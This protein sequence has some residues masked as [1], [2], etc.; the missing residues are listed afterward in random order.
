M[1]ENI[2]ILLDFISNIY[3]FLFLKSYINKKLFSSFNKAD[4]FFLI[5][6]IFI[7]VP[8]KVP[9]RLLF[10]AIADFIYIVLSKKNNVATIIKEY[11]HIQLVLFL[12]S[13]IIFL[14]HSIIFTDFLQF[15]ENDTYL[16]FKQHICNVLLFTVYQSYLNY[17]ASASSSKVISILFSVI[18]HITIFSLSYLIIDISQNIYNPTSLLTITVSILFLIISIILSLY[19]RFIE[20]TNKKI[21]TDEQLARAL[22]LKDYSYQIESSLKEVHSIRHD[23][24]NNLL[25]IRKYAQENRTDK[26]SALANDILGRLNS[27]SI[28]DTGI[29]IISAI[30]NTKS[31]EAQSH[32]INFE[33]TATISFLSI[34]DTDIIIILGNVLDN[35]ITAARKCKNRYIMISLDQQNDLLL[36]RCINNYT[37]EI[38]KKGELFISSKKNDGLIHGIG[39]ENVRKTV[40]K[41]GGTSDFRHKDGVFTVE[42]ILPNYL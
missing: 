8:E 19:H 30:L 24:K 35:A 26:I 16:Y 20:L 21:E 12:F 1:Q 14:M 11:I 36:L 32:N 18:V 22:L 28:I 3:I 25:I 4:C 40:L 27:S 17:K 37:G 6:C 38:K 31:A 2:R 7:S 39:I 34:A 5:F 23:I 13:N 41:L 33:Y 10:F 15:I 42:I 9:Y 29:P